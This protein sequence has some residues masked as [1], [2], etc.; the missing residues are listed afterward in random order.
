M[1]T[2]LVLT[3]LLGVL[4]NSSCS[5]AQSDDPTAKTH[6]ESKKGGKKD[7]K[8]GKKNKEDTL[9]NRFI[10]AAIPG[11]SKLAVISKVPE[12]S[13]LALAD[14]PGTFYTNADA[15]NS[16]TLYKV[17]LKGNLLQEIN[18]PVAN[19]DWESLA[20]DDKGNLYVVDA[21]NNN[22][23]R[24]NLV[25]Y[26][27]NPA[28]PQQVSQIPFSYADQTDFPPKKEN[29]NF[30]CEASIW[31]AG[32]LYL[33]TKDRAQQS[34][35]KVYTLNDQPGQQTAKLIAKLAIPGE[36]TDANLSPDGKRLAL[37]GREELFILEGNDLNAIFKATPRRI[38]LG[39][40][41]QTEGLVFTDNQTLIIS[42]EQGSL[43]QYKL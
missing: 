19:H 27:L 12:S 30:D 22:N 31:H 17:D 39:G 43:Y 41:G 15:G 23:S 21:G 9:E 8:K 18:L 34:T 11:L 32:K 38:D 10:D 28:A 16:P 6:K 33:F 26:R 3:T 7:G 13:S 25:V 40:A 36:V 2:L 37:L 29:R 42:T 1:R 5:Q 4:S 14:Q 35:S 20:K 24:K